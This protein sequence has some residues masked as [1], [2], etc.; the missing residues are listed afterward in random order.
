MLESKFWMLSM[1]V[2]LCETREN[3]LFTHDP[4][5]GYEENVLLS[6]VRYLRVFHSVLVV[7]MIHCVSKKIP[8]TWCWDEPW[9]WLETIYILY[10]MMQNPMFKKK[11]TYYI[12]LEPTKD[13]KSSRFWLNR[14]CSL[15]LEIWHLHLPKNKFVVYTNVFFWADLVSFYTHAEVLALVRASSWNTFV[16]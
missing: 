10:T 8:D 4:A 3:L 9:A 13:R 14:Q 11:K 15:F 1:I 5:T 6:S 7:R 2:R 12:W 16:M